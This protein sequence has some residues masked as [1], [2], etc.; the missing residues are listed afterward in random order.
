M[1]RFLYALLCLSSFFGICAERA[2]IS[3]FG[4]IGAVHSNS[5][6]YRFRTDISRDNDNFEDSLD[7]SAISSLGIQADISLFR[8]FDLV[9]QLIYR[10]QK[11]VTLDNALSLAFL[12]YKPAPDWELRVGRTQLDLYLLTEYRDIGFAYPWA[13]VPTEVYAL[14]PYRNLDGADFTYFKSHNDLDYRI[15][16]FGG[17]SSSHI[18]L[19][20]EN[21]ELKI[22]D[23]LGVSFELSQFDWTLSLKH[24][25][26]RTKNNISTMASIIGGLQ[27]IPDVIWP[28][29][30][31]FINDFSLI[32]KKAYF[33]SAGLKYNLGP[34]TFLTEFAHLHSDSSVVSAVSSG[35]I[36]TTYNFDKGQLFYTFAIVESD[37]SEFNDAVNIQRFLPNQVEE[38]ILAV[39]ESFRVFSPNQQT[40]SLGV[41]YDVKDNIALKLQID[42]TNI[43]AQGGALWS[44]Q[45][46]NTLAPKESF[47][48]LFFSVSFTF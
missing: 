28:D 40:H 5:D 29:K 10:G 45:G 12:R 36:S 16:L 14:L 13:K 34:L 47:T 1:L 39:N 38:I 19:D 41:R 9:T 4:N 2:T 18:A 24:T 11:K 32:N 23:V 46:M 48:T 15:K 33:S 30:A 35:Y 8:D 3:G 37:P 20:N 43:E 42:H 44:Y 17:Q 6:T 26:A 25:Q 7:F 21:V 27:Q 22:D 31:A